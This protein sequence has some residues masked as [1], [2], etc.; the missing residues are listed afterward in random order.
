[1]KSFE[2]AYIYFQKSVLI[3]E[4]L[5]LSDEVIKT[6]VKLEETALRLS[7]DDEANTWKTTRESL[8]AN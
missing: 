5:S 1:M 3:Y 7:L 8:E 6:L 2:E 4:V